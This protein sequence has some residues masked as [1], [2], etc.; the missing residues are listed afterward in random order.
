V[1]VFPETIDLMPTFVHAP[2]ALAAAF[3][4]ISGKDEESKSIDRKAIN[5]LFIFSYTLLGTLE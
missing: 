4:E 3:A 1:K 2:P 5:L